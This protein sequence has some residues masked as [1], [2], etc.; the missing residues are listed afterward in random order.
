MNNIF[1]SVGL[2]LAVSSLISLGLMFAGIS[3]LTSFIVTTIIQFVV[4]FIVGSTL[5]FIN[6]IKLKEIDA[7]RLTELSKQGMEVECPCFKKHKEFVPVSLTGNNTYKC[8]DCGKMNNVYVTT[9]TVH[10]TE[11]ITLQNNGI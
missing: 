4:F 6:E 9:E 8:T 11:P 2:T 1:R 3:F 7:I 10:V 5:E